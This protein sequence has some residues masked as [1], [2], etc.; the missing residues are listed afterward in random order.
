VTNCNGQYCSHVGWDYTTG[1]GTPDVGNLMLDI[2]GRT[3]PTRVTTPNPPPTITPVI[4][5]TTCPGPQIVDG[6]NDAPNVYPAGDGANMDNLD[7]VSASFSSPNATTLRVTMT[8]KNLSAPPPP[9]N[10]GGALWAVFWNYNGT[11]YY[12]RAESTGALGVGAFKFDDGTFTSN[13]NP[14]NQAVSG[15]TTT[16]PNGTFVIDVP[17][18]DVGNPPSGA[19]LTLPFAESHGSFQLVFY[20]AAADRA[21]DLGF[22]APWTIGTTCP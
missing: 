1:F 13:F 20:T 19:Q 12:A 21:P 6:V 3:A 15:T 17:L 2:D 7:I 4:S 5:G 8:I 22:G 10:L 9:V 14:V 11:T 18:A 16:G